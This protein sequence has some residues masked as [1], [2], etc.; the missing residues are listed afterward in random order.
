MKRLLII[1]CF[2]FACFGQS[3]EEAKE[4]EKTIT[5]E[6][7]KKHIS[8]FASDEME[9]RETGKNGQ[10]LAAEYFTNQYLNYDIPFIDIA[11]GYKQPYDLIERKNEGITI[12]INGKEYNYFNGFYS[13]KGM[14][15]DTHL[16]NSLIFSGYGI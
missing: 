6:D 13:H 3:L 10:K 12:S 8:I 1:L 5:A 15:D 16:F 11:N 4:F 9:G 7:L 14:R 2:P